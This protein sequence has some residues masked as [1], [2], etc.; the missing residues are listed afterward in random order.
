V[1]R[2]RNARKRHELAPETARVLFV[3]EIER[4][5]SGRIAN[6]QAALVHGEK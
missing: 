1:R 4:Q 6:V 3:R 2:A 5:F